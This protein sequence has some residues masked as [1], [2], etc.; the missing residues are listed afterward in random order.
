MKMKNYLFICFC[1]LMCLMGCTKIHQHSAKDPYPEKKPR[2]ERV[3]FTYGT[4]SKKA[5]VSGDTY[6]VK[7]G[8]TLYSISLLYD[9]NYT[10]IAK[11]NNIKS[12]YR[13]SVG[14]QIIIKSNKYRKTIKKSNTKYLLV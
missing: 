10:K 12:P 1:T 3:Y 4:Q 13:V 7:Q 9:V 6:I 8:D 5:S 14:D 2:K 11:W